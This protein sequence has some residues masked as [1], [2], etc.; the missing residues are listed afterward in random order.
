MNC[1]K[2]KMHDINNDDDDDNYCNDDDIK[3]RA[4]GRAQSTTNRDLRKK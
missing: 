1:Q 3:C 4:L 2:H